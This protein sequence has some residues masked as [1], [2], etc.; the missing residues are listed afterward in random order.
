MSDIAL[1]AGKGELPYYWAKNSAKNGIRPYIFK[2]TGDNSLSFEKFGKDIFEV[3]LGKIAELFSLL[4]KKNIKRVV[5]AGKVEKNNIYDLKMDNRMKKILSN[6]ENYNDDTI[7]RAIGAE[8]EK[9]GFEIVPQI[10]AMADLLVKPGSLNEIKTDKT[11]NSEMEF[12]FINALEIGKLDIGQTVLTKDKSVVAV[13]AMEGT[14][15]A[16]LRTGEIAGKGSVMA[17]VA[18]ENQD[19]R[20]DI[21]TVGLKTLENLKKIKAKAL[22]I[23]A[24]KTFIINREEFLKE[25]TKA[26]IAVRACFYD[27]GGIKW[28]E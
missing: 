22:V 15:K 6:I 18:K 8:F 26:D 20:F 28:E 25:A 23:E 17:K 1:I 10:E 5:F 4:H 7:L 14:D 21:P 24:N 9:E 13:E 16:I 19:L 2:I 3:E 11:L 12:A 27:S